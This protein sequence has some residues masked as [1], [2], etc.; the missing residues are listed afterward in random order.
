MKSIKT[1]FISFVLVLIILSIVVP[2]YFLITQFRANFNQRS[3][4]MLEATLD[5][6]N[7]TID[8][9]M[10]RGDQK[11]IQALVEELGNRKGI[12]HIR[13]LSPDG[14]VKYSSLHSNDREDLVTVHDNLHPDSS[15]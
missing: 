12:D 7:Y 11:N 6:L 8:N 9:A 1:K 13:I 3:V 5:L 15:S 2:I 10:M 14:K 4:I